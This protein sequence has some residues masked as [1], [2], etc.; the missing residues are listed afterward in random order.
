MKSAEGFD[1]IIGNLVYYIEGGAIAHQ[2]IRG[3]DGEHILFS[4]HMNPVGI[5][6]GLCYVDERNAQSYL[7]D[8]GSES[9]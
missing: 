9:I 6:P 3:F 5:L 7:R 4:G 8:H 2:K 1:L